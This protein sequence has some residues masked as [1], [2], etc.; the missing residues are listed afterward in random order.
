M[1]KTTRERRRGTQ[2][3]GILRGSSREERPVLNQIEERKGF[4]WRIVSGFIVVLLSGLLFLFFFADAF[5][6]TSIRV[7]RRDRLN[8]NK[9]FSVR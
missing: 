9:P 5:Y 8:R 6:V 2:Y 7:G 1:A 3:T 4:N